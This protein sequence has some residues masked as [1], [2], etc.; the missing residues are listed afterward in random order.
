M[1]HFYDLFRFLLSFMHILYSSSFVLAVP[2]SVHIP[3]VMNHCHVYLDVNS[4]LQVMQLQSLQSYQNKAVSSAA[5]LFVYVDRAHAL[6]V[7]TLSS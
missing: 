6:P 5:L 1:Q 7:S 3:T 4:L 2:L